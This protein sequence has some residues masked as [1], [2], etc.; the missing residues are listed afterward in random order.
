LGPTYRLAGDCSAK[1]IGLIP[2]PENYKRIS[3]GEERAEKSTNKDYRVNM[4][5]NTLR[6]G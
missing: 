1:G 4:S 3:G 6:R 5:A 2:F